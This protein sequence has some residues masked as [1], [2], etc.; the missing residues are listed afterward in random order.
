MKKNYLY[1]ILAVIFLA[2]V[3]FLGLSF[4]F[5]VQ[6]KKQLTERSKEFVQIWGNYQDEASTS[7]INSLKDYI[8]VEIMSDYQNNAQTINYYYSEGYEPTKSILVEKTEPK[9]KKENK[10]YLV[11]LTAQR[12]LVDVKKFEQNITL[13]WQRI[14]GA[15]KIVEIIAN[16]N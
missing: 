14:D 11:I 8:S 13:R 5:D 15:Y 4:Y 6:N 7:Y 12:E 10:N 16:D 9:I 2:I 3:I 1:L